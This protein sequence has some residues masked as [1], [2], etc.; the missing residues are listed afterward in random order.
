MTAAEQI[1]LLSTTGCVV[2]DPN[3]MAKITPYPVEEIEK[4][5]L[6]LRYKARQE[7]GQMSMSETLWYLSGMKTTDD[8][9][10]EI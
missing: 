1:H 9:L 4:Q 5:W 2:R 7:Y 3:R 8:D 10:I 6:E